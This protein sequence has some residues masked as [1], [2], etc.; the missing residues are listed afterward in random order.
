MNRK[1][2]IAGWLVAA[3]VAMSALSGCSLLPG[4][5]GGSD[6]PDDKPPKIEVGGNG[7]VKNSIATYTGENG[8]YKL[9][10]DV[11]ALKRYDDVTRLVF[12]VTPQSQGGTDPLPSDFFSNESY[13][14]DVTAVYLL[15]TKNM[16][17]YPVLMGGEECVCANALGD[18]PLDQPTALYADYPAPPDSV[19]SMTVVFKNVGPLPGVEV[20]S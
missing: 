14:N 11:I 9:T 19:E 8:S 17:K 15:D 12:T 10:M 5:G 4:G 20:S 6:I 13:G 3:A 18:Y 16:R 1:P 2:R 7:K